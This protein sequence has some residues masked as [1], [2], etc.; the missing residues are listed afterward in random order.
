MQMQMH[1]AA[2]SEKSACIQK[3]TNL[4]GQ[5]VER[6]KLAFRFW[7][8]ALAWGHSSHLLCVT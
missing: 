3:A 4:H 6:E 1:K 5:K 8:L 7:V 2:R